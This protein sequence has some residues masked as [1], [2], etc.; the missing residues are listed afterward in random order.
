MVANTWE[1]H[2]DYESLCKA[3]KMIQGVTEFVNKDIE[4]S[5]AIQKVVLIQNSLGGEAQVKLVSS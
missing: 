3:L 1:D 5:S 2:V 4:T